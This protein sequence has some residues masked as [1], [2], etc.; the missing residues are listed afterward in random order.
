MAKR[1]PKS[2]NRQKIFKKLFQYKDGKLFHKARLNNPYFNRRWA[3]TEAGYK[4]KHANKKM[5][6]VFI[7]I[8]FSVDGVKYKENAN[9]IVWSMFNG[10]IAEGYAIARHNHD[11]LDNRIENLHCI[12]IKLVAKNQKLQKRI[13]GEVRTH[14]DKQSACSGV[15]WHKPSDKWRARIG[16]K[17]LGWFDT[18]RE[19]VVARK[20]AEEREGFHMN[21]GVALV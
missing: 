3:G 18:E 20:Q 9:R 19:A 21:H 16:T 10:D 11:Y 8:G 13:D 2:F 6:A 12:P 7:E 4:K 1:L 5:D 14:A 15:S 17:E